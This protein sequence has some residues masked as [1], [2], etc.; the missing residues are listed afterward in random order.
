MQMNIKSADAHA[1]AVQVARL[2]GESLTQ[3]ITTALRERLKQ[4]Q[5]EQEEASTALLK[6]GRGCAARLGGTAAMQSVD[7]LLYD[8]H[9]LPK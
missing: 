6:I 3:A 4:V 5:R 2:T 8:P 9:G 1:L 7:D